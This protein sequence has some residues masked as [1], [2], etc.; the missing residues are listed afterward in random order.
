MSCTTKKRGNMSRMEN[1]RIPGAAPRDRPSLRWMPVRS[2][3]S[4]P[5]REA[6]SFYLTSAVAETRPVKTGAR[7]TQQLSG[8]VNLEIMT[9]KIDQLPTR[10]SY[11][12]AAMQCTEKPKCQ[13]TH[14]CTTGIRAHTLTDSKKQM[15]KPFPVWFNE[16]IYKKLWHHTL[17]DVYKF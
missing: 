14:I 16:N 3:G 2:P 5:S 10:A 7:L 12:Q 1:V 17:T 15:H 8:C 6:N 9:S 4:K 13:A 11:I